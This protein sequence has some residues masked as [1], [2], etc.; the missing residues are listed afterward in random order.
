MVLFEWIHA[1]KTAYWSIENPYLIHEVLLHYV[2]VGVPW[3]GGGL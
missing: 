1:H 2:K 3:T